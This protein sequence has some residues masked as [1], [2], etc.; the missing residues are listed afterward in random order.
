MDLISFVSGIGPTAAFTPGAN[1][2]APYNVSHT[3]ATDGSS[4]STSTN[5]MAEIMNRLLLQVAAV[6]S[7]S[8]LTIDNLN[9]TQLLAAVRKI[10]LD[11]T[12]AGAYVT[13]AQYATDFATV[14]SGNGYQSFAGGV[15]LQ[16]GSFTAPGGGSTLAVTFPIAFPTAAYAAVGNSFDAANILAINSITR[17]AV[18]VK[19][20]GG[21]GYY[22]AIG[23]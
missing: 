7:G 16:W 17:F 10:A 21:T 6:I 20:G 15:I 11:T 14:K 23:S 22:F 13:L 1:T 8:G 5:N 2:P 4:P 12:N 9:W 19:N 3:G 18:T